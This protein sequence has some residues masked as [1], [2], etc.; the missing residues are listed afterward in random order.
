MQVCISV[1]DEKGSNRAFGTTTD[2]LHE[3]THWLLGHKIT[4]VAMEATGVYWIPLFNMLVKNGITALLLNAADVKNYTARK[5][6]VNDAE[7]LMTLMSYDLVKPSF[8]IDDYARALRNCTR[9]RES[10]VRLSSDCIRRI[11]KCLELMNVKLTEVL[12]EV[13]G[14][15]GIRIIEAIIAGDK[16]PEH[17]STLASTRCKKSRE[18]IAAA[19]KGTWDEE[20]IFI[21][22]QQYQQYRL[23]Q[24]QI[25][26][27]DSMIE[28]AMKSILDTV[29]SSNGGEIKQY[30]PTKKKNN[31]GNYLNFDVEYYSAQIWGV[32]LMAID[33]VS[34]I[35]V[36]SLMGELGP[37]FVD[38]FKDASHFCSWCNLC[39]HDKISGGKLLSSHRKKRKNPVGLILRNCA[40]PLAKSKGVMGDYYRRMKA[41]GGG[42]FA[43]CATAHKIATIIYTM[44]KNQTTY[45]NTKVSV[46][47]KDWLE[48]K[49]KRQQRI[50]EKLQKQK[51][52][53]ID[54]QHY[55]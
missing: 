45:D 25:T 50:L 42:K 55:K 29:L 17:L 35:T 32:N 44:V 43:I 34:T 37:N 24:S 15:S 10:M 8:Q 46:S 18:E 30:T 51:M 27:M 20:L 11:Q 38:S 12:S 6:D 28:K 2:E 13:S 7:W 40:Q 39:P 26:K 23:L 3:I 14:D 36:L 4:H 41:K 48:S 33:G 54:H 22:D 9:H 1:E 21:L 5:T 53:L 52:Q 31:K 19:L 49:I 47:D 16:D